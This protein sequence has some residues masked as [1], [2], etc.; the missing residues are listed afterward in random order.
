M[1]NAYTDTPTFTPALFCA[2]LGRGAIDQAGQ[3]R[4]LSDRL[5]I[6]TAGWTG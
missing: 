3:A 2:K 4:I 1:K 6:S 5:V